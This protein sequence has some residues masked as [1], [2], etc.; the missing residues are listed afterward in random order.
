M[1]A[2]PTDIDGYLS[3]LPDDARVTI[4]ELRSIIKA[5]APDAVEGISYGMLSFKDQ[6]ER[7]I[8]FAAA[9]NHCALYGT[10]KGAI[11]FPRGEPLPEELVK[12]LVNARIADIEVAAAG[13]KRGESGAGTST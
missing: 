13:R 8:Y 3:T 2:T 4:Q 9:K 1:N 11:R 12:T 5:V 7:L 10:S 6:G